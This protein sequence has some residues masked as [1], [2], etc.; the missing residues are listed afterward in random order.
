MRR[1]YLAMKNGCWKD[2]KERY[3]KEGKSSEWTFEGIR[4]AYEKV[5]KDEIG[6][7]GIVQEI[8]RKSTDFLR[9]IIAAVDGMA[10][11]TL[12]YVCPHCNSF[13]LEDYMWWVSSGYGDGNHRK[14]STATCFVRLLES[15]TNGERPTEYCGAARCEF[16]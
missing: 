8:L 7:L 15:T 13:R 6:R 11:V 3:K 16:Q 5:A 9:R 14:K 4:E 1:G 12:S 10:G 2:L